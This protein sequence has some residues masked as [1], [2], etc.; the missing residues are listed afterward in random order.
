[1]ID[2]QLIFLLQKN[3][4]E[5]IE[6]RTLLEKSRTIKLLSLFKKKQFHA[7]NL[8]LKRILFS[9]QNSI[10][11]I[12]MFCLIVQRVNAFNG[13][14]FYIVFFFS[15]SFDDYVIQ[16]LVFN[17]LVRSLH[18]VNNRAHLLFVNTIT[19]HQR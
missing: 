4:Y 13:F 3:I 17:F 8:I 10:A 15:S 7:N 14:Y 5:T 1:M 11:N 16:F 18:P 19:Y 9:G 6:R 2:F 12:A